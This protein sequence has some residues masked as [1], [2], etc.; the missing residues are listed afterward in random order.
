M[1]KKEH[2]MENLLDTSNIELL[3]F[4]TNEIEMDSNVMV[5]E[6]MKKYSEMTYEERQKLIDDLNKDT[7]KFFQSNYNRSKERYKDMF[8]TYSRIKNENPKLAK[9]WLKI[10]NQEEKLLKHS[11]KLLKEWRKKYGQ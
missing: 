8:M 4:Q 7:G 2:E 9:M 10:M 3:E 11:E 5:E 6:P 1:K